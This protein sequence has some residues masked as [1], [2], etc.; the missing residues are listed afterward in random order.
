MMSGFEIDG[1]TGK[2]FSGSSFFDGCE[3]TESRNFSAEVRFEAELRGLRISQC[4]VG[5][6]FFVEDIGR[7]PL[8]F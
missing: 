2:S 7:R 5:R 1:R 8:A 3:F 4:Q 6:V